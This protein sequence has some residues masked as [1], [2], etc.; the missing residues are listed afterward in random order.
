M[1]SLTESPWSHKSDVEHEAVQKKPRVDVEEVRQHPLSPKSD[2]KHEAPP[3][4]VLNTNQSHYRICSD[5]DVGFCIHIAD[6]TKPEN[7]K[8]CSCDLCFWERESYLIEDGNTNS[9]PAGYWWWP[10]NHEFSPDIDD[11][12]E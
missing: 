9:P 7:I 11:F 6:V 4:N 10:S 5:A 1:S 3:D 2:V 8:R 12:Q